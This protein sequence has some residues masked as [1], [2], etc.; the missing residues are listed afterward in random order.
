[1]I[2]FWTTC[3][4]FVVVVLG[5]VCALSGFNI[6]KFL[7]MIKDELLIIVGTS[8][9]DAVL[10]R[11]LAKLEAAACHPHALEVNAY[12]VRSLHRRHAL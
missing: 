10:P 5:A 6:V 2:A 7:R 12:I 3:I 11:L 1:M 9:S 8:T 4:F